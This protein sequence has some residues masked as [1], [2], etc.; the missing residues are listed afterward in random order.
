M[1][2][3]AM[4]A[5]ASRADVDAFAKDGFIHLK[6]FFHPD[7]LLSIGDEITRLTIVLNTQHAP[8]KE[9]STYD[10]AFV[11][12]MNLWERSEAVKAFVFSKR[13]ARAAAALL[14]VRSVR[15]YHDQSLYKEPGGGFT[16]AH[17]DQYYWPIDTDRAVTA[18]IPLQDTPRA[19]GPLAFYRG[20][21]TVSVG[22]DL[23]ISDESERCVRRNMEARGFAYVEEPFALGDVSFH[24]G[25]TFHRAGENRSD[26]ARSVMTIIYMDAS[27][28]IAGDLN[29]ARENDRR[30][31]CPG[32]RLGDVAASPKNPILYTV[33]RHG[34]QL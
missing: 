32:V 11:Q 31:W 6:R 5:E 7:E 33:D 19:M 18:W 20:S 4:T 2:E 12:V 26:R 22:R 24:L 8:I 9:R 27:A 17:A 21:H 23:P 13:L 34:A 14:G 10:K 15:L 30:Q 28:R 16:P 1:I 3:H 25:W 29:P